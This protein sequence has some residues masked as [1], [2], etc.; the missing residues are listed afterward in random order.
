MRPARQ[1][2]YV[3][4]QLE[5][6]VVRWRRSAA[7]PSTSPAAVPRSV[8]S[9]QPREKRRSPP[10]PQKCELTLVW[11]APHFLANSHPQRQTLRDGK[12]RIAA[13]AATRGSTTARRPQTWPPLGREGSTPFL[14]QPQPAPHGRGRGAG[15][16]PSL[17]CLLSPAGRL[18]QVSVIVKPGTGRRWGMETLGR[19]FKTLSCCLIVRRPLETV[20]SSAPAS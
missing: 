17:H 13:A 12:W 2:R 14:Q 10:P 20:M 3:P 4:P 15:V 5:P 19:G 1:L 18:I 11:G 9:P 16:P 6:R 7:L 8:V